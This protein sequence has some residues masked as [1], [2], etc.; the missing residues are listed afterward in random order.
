M[1]QTYEKLSLSRKALQTYTKVG[2]IKTESS[3][4]QTWA[5]YRNVTA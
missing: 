3:L 5:M 4:V 1:Q 2:G